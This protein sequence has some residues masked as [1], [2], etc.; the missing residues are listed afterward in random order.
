MRLSIPSWKRTLRALGYKVVRNPISQ[1]AQKNRNRLKL[2]QQ[3]D[4]G[5]LEP[6][7]MMAGDT[8]LVVQAELDDL[9]TTIS[10]PIVVKLGQFDS[11]DS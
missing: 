7:Q 3:P 2:N 10:N 4:Y 5:A 9:F 6:R 8:G 1:R 11:N